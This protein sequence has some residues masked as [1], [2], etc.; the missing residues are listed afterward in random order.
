V[1]S[2][3]QLVLEQGFL[4]LQQ[5]CSESDEQQVV[6]VLCLGVVA[7]VHLV[8]GSGALTGYLGGVAGGLDSCHP[9]SMAGTSFSTS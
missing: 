2:V 7:A 1:S 3:A 4:G 6:V 5:S 9:R 8:P